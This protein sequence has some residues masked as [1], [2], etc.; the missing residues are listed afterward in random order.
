VK[1]ALAMVV[2]F[3]LIPFIQRSVDARRA[4]L[5]GG[6]DVLYLWSGQHVRRLSPGLENVLADIYWLR[7]VQ[8]FGGQ[9][10]FA[11]HKR[12]DLLEPL[13][14]IT[15]TL[16]PRFELAYRYGAIFLAEPPPA[17]AGQPQAAIKLLKR[18]AKEL[19]NSW[20]IRQDLGFFHHFFLGESEEAARILLEAV[21]I[22][23]APIWFRTTAADFLRRGGERETS[24]N[25]WRHLAEETE[26]QMRENALFNLY[27]LDALDVMDAQQAAV[28]EFRRRF[29][30]WP[31]ALGELAGAGIKSP[32][33]DT[34]GVPFAYD[35][36]TGR[37]SMGRTSP[38]WRA[39]E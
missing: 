29:G 5:G 32:L 18:A 16:D 4:A 1:Q 14:D 2:L 35:P 12:F 30:R 31:R 33:A 22:P 15:T 28:E 8:Y 10:A 6:E 25:V 17:G 36:E 34:A 24:R 21:D 38:F 7:T 37:V 13:I 19:P 3:A 20:R 11:K 9:I 27:R 23:G 39:L 26:G